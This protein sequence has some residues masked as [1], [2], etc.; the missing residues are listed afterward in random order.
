MKKD[1]AF[2]GKGSV[3]GVDTEHGSEMEFLDAKA[4]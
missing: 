4:E 2:E 3:G 1:E